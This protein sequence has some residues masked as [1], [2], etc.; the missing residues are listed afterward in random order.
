[1][2]STLA[3]FHLLERPALFG[4]PTEAIIGL[5]ATDSGSQTPKTANASLRALAERVQ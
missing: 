5:G 3:I 4:K 1:M 2:I